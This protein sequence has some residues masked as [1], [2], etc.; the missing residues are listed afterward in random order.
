MKEKQPRGQ[1]S[2]NGTKT[3]VGIKD[4]AHNDVWEPVGGFMHLVHCKG[5]PRGQA[6]A[7]AKGWMKPVPSLLV[8][9]ELNAYT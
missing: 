7:G 8:R 2:G 3:T 6:R 4:P 1:S 9:V 5:R